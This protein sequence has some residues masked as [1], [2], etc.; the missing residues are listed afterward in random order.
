MSRRKKQQEEIRKI[1][2]AAEEKI[3]ELKKEYDDKI[4]RQEEEIFKSRQT[5]RKYD[6]LT[7]V[8]KSSNYI[9]PVTGRPGIS[10][11][12]RN[13]KQFLEDMKDTGMPFV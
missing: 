13:R 6:E 2:K 9:D 5:I 3:E 7:R 4:K 1:N 8:N 12:E 11:E 10:D